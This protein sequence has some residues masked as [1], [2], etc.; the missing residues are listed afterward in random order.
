MTGISIF[1]LIHEKEVN[2]YLPV[3]RAKIPLSVETV[4][5]VEEFIHALLILRVNIII[6]F[7]KCKTNSLLIGKKF[8]DFRTE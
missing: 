7:I 1:G 2:H 8:H 5:E 4:D 3:A 6:F